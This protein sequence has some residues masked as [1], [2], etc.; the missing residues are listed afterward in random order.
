MLGNKD[1]KGLHL[2]TLAMSF[3]RVHITLKLQEKFAK[4]KFPLNSL[5]GILSK[6]RNPD[7][8]NRKSFYLLL[9]YSD[10]NSAENIS[11]GFFLILCLGEKRL[12]LQNC[13]P[14]DCKL[15]FVMKCSVLISKQTLFKSKA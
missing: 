12:I 15:A 4:A 11:F 13:E 3:T 6:S 5:I 14:H 1:Q 2:T 10:Q 9:T 8:I 7:P